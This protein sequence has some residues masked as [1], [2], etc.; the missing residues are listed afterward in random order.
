M[1]FEISYLFYLSRKLRHLY[2]V[3]G[4]F[5]NLR[6]ETVGFFMS[7]Y[8]LAWNNSAP[9]SRNIIKFG[10]CVLFEICLENSDLIK[11]RQE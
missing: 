9:T 2:L 7:V 3:V 1:K 4:A 5:A 8:L 10:I 6:K 11:V